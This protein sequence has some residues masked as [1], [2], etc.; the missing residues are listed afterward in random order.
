MQTF[1]YCYFRQN[2]KSSV[3]TLTHT[4]VLYSLLYLNDYFLKPPLPVGDQFVDHCFVFQS[5][6]FI[7][8]CLKRPPSLSDHFSLHQEWSL[9]RELSVFK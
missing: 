8:F 7:D 5:V 9:K 1:I 3:V 4:V 2:V 6:W